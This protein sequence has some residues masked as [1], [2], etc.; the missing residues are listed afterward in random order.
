MDSK[1]IYY[2]ILGL[3]VLVAVVF[4]LLIF[5]TQWGDYLILAR[6]V[7]AAELGVYFW[8][9]NMSQQVAQLLG[10]NIANVVFVAADVHGWSPE[11]WR[12]AFVSGAELPLERL[13]SPNAAAIKRLGPGGFPSFPCTLKIATFRLCARSS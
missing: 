8:A 1:T 3:A 9:F 13:E 7:D 10:Y 6:F 12:E 2:I 11:A 4:S 5:V